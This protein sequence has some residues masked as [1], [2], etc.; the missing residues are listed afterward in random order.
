MCVFLIAVPVLS[1]FLSMKTFCVKSGLSE[2]PA[3][4][5]IKPFISGDS[6]RKSRLWT[7]WIDLANFIER[8][9]KT[10]G[11]LHCAR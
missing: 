9:R 3:H 4:R 8:T 10:N 7:S 1:R 2:V 11:D 6:L 5:A